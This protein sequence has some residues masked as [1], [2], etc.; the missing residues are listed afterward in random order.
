MSKS[1]TSRAATVATTKSDLVVRSH[2]PPGLAYEEYREYLRPD[3]FFSCAY[4]TIGESEAGGIR[5]AIDHYEPQRHCP[6]LKDV[7][8]NLMY[9]CNQCN[10]LK[11]DRTPSGELRA[12]GYLLFRPDQHLYAEH[13]DRTGFRL[14]KKTNI[15]Y[16][17]IER[18][19]LNRQSLRRLREIRQRVA[20]CHEF[21]FGGV[22]ALRNFPLDQLP[23]NVRG[24]ANG[25]IKKAVAF[26]EKIIKNVD[27]MLRETARSP[28]IDEDEEAR[29]R[30]RERAAKLKQL[31]ALVPGALKTTRRR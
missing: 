21:V 3:F 29:S 13:F 6:D 28:L 18:L 30:S 23:P 14:T 9:A 11:G 15:G 22:M 2:V 7:Y 12:Q 8:D 19:D 26:A 25:Y 5:F 24:R 16:Y 27:D 4:C 20:N 17:T 31:E 10:V 1:P